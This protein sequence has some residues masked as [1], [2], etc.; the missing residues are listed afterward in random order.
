MNSIVLLRVILLLIWYKIIFSFTPRL[1]Y[2]SYIS[3][4]LGSYNIN[5]NGQTTTKVLTSLMKSDDGPFEEFILPFSF[6]FLG[7]DIYIVYLLV[8]MVQ[9]IQILIS[10]VLCVIV[11]VIL[12]IVV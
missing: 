6:P 5:Y 2:I 8:L 10:H 7:S 9:F 11:L 12:K 4:T 3:N 1:E